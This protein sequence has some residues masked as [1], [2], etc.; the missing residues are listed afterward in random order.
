MKK[1]VFSLLS[2]F[3]MFFAICFS[4]FQPN[5][6]FA[7]LWLSSALFAYLIG[8]YD[9][10]KLTFFGNSVQVAKLENSLQKIKDVTEVNTKILLE[11]MQTQ[12]RT[13][14]SFSSSKKMNYFS[15]LNKIL[16][17]SGF[18]SEEIFELTKSWHRWNRDLYVREI[19]YS[20]AM[21]HPSVPEDKMSDWHVARE[22]IFAEETP[23]Q[24]SPEKLKEIFDGF[25]IKDTKLW[26]LI[27]DYKFYFENCE[28][29]RPEVWSDISCGKISNK[30]WKD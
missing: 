4:I 9:L 24:I 8:W 5:L 13:F 18:T 11:L 2:I 16:N 21:N 7:C 17:S 22:K 1:M 20:S 14:D 25:D 28:H 15:E 29:R 6:G 19:A 23:L 10:E 27:E 30:Y 3:F 12:G 26:D